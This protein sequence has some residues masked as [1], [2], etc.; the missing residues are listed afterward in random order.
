MKADSEFLNHLE[1]LIGDTA[2]NL[3]NE[4]RGQ[5]FATILFNKA[6]LLYHTRQTLRAWKLLRILLKCLN[7]FDATFVQRIG[8][9]SIEILLNL[10]Q[11][12]KVKE[13]IDLMTKRLRLRT[14][15]RS[16]SDTD[17]SKKPEDQVKCVVIRNLDYFQW[18]FRMYKIRAKVM[19]G[20]AVTIPLE[21][22][23]GVQ[24]YVSTI[25][26]LMNDFD[27]IE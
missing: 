11:P 22:V 1:S 3:F 4:I 5:S 23:R 2:P 19:N 27:N 26:S 10:N 7:Q 17:D 16:G 6:I 9:L 13:I 24:Q 15:S 20:T 21:E 14:D 8:L 18:M 12:T 25:F